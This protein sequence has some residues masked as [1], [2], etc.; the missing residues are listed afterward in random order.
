[1]NSLA[2][3]IGGLTTFSTSI[4]K[5]E[6][7]NMNFETQLARLE[8]ID[9]STLGTCVDQEHCRSANEFLRVA[10]EILVGSDIAVETP[11]FEPEQLFGATAVLPEQTTDEFRAKLSKR[12]C[13]QKGYG[14]SI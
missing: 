10:S 3:E 1:M 12:F 14:H 4:L 9:W 7:Q 13:R 5:P 11:F 6:P 8:A 2:L